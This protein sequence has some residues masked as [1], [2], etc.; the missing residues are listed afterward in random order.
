MTGAG[1]WRSDDP[2]LS[3]LRW[4]SHYPGD[5]RLPLLNDMRE[6][7]GQQIRARGDLRALLASERD[8]ITHRERTGAKLPIQGHGLW[9]RMHPHTAEVTPEARL[10]ISP[11]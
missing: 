6:L 3:L 2:L 4:L 10:E 11:R 5:A 1:A 7:M 9:V 8:V